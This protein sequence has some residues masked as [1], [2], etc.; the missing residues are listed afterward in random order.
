M[1]DC[2]ISYMSFSFSEFCD[3][4]GIVVLISGITKTLR[5]LSFANSA[6]GDVRLQVLVCLHPHPNTFNLTTQNTSSNYTKHFRL[7]T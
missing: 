3:C 7:T 5:Q 6:L 4:K 2:I 1:G